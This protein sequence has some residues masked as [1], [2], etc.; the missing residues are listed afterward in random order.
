MLWDKSVSL[1]QLAI[2]MDHGS[3]ANI[4]VR[5]LK[6]KEGEGFMWMAIAH[7][8]FFLIIFF[9]SHVVWTFKLQNISNLIE[10]LGSRICRTKAIHVP[11]P[12]A[13]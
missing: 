1:S 6:A 12:R 7:W 2:S 13:S 4:Q 8:F 3:V 10:L 11:P 5:T 9:T